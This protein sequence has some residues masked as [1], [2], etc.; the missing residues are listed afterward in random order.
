LN[1][2]CGLCDQ[3]NNL[4]HNSLYDSL[5]F[6]FDTQ[7][8]VLNDAA[9]KLKQVLTDDQ[10]KQL[11]DFIT[12]LQTKNI[13]KAK[14]YKDLREDDITKALTEI[15][16]NSF[17]YEFMEG[18]IKMYMKLESYDLTSEQIRKALGY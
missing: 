18:N 15:A 4:L 10:L 9:D 14:I 8:Q 17:N 6:S 16:H 5:L 3:F 12:D 11:K 2:K 1:D 13:Y 7:K